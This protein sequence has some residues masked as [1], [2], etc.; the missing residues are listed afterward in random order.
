MV[1]LLLFVDVKTDAIF[2]TKTEWIPL[3]ASFSDWS[4]AAS[5]M[6]SRNRLGVE[7]PAARVRLW[8]ARVV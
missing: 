6:K 8:A 3:A 5:A 4:V 1:L 2:T 7:R